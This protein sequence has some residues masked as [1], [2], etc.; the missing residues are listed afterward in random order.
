MGVGRAGQGAESVG[1]ADS[2]VFSICMVGQLSPAAGH[3]S[4]SSSSGVEGVPEWANGSV[5]KVGVV[6][7]RHGAE[8]VGEANSDALTIFARYVRGRTSISSG[9][10]ISYSQRQAG[11]PK[12]LP[13]R[14][15]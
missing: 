15:W 12:H 2:S 9:L 5:A 1:E 7:V 3:Y 4:S 11:R 8:G 6:G 14:L 10:R 13:G